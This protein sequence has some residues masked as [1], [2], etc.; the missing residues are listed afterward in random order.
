[1]KGN[2]QRP[3]RGDEF[4]SLLHSNGPI[5][6]DDSKDDSVSSQPLCHR[7][8]SMHSL[9]LVLAVAKITTAGTDHHMQIGAHVIAYDGDRALTW[10]DSAFHVIAEQFHPIRPTSFGCQRCIDRMGC[11]FHQSFP[12]RHCHFREIR[13]RDLQANFRNIQRL[14]D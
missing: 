10:S 13:S 1:M 7:N 5:W 8:I 3:G 9:Q 11:Y 2:G 4:A 12:K 14:P 6:I